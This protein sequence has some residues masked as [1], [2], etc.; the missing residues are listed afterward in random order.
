MFEIV[1][2]LNIDLKHH[3]NT[4][5][6]RTEISFF[7]EYAMRRKKHG[8]SISLL[9]CGNRIICGNRKIWNHMIWNKWTNEENTMF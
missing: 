6:L 5:Y 7:Y 2:Y 8:E 4:F 1:K 3:Y 9:I